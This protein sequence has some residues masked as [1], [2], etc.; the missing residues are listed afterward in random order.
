MEV[1]RNSDY[2]SNNNNIIE[3]G[4]MSHYNN[5]FMNQNKKAY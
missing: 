3:N 4:G 5:Y 1:R 2:I